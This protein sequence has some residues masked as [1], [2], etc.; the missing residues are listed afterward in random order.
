MEEEEDIKFIRRCLDLA[1][2]AEGSTTP[3]P[4]VGSV[5]VHNGR[6]IGEGYHLKSGGPH[7]EVIAINSVSDKSLLSHSTLYVNLEPCSH[8]GKTPPCADYIISEHIPRVVVGT[9]D[10][11]AK[12]SGQGVS[13]LKDAGCEVITGVCEDECRRLNRRFFTF[14]EK[15]RPYI[16]LKWAKSA[17]G[18]ID[19]NRAEGSISEPTW[20]SG[21]PERVLVHRWRASEEAIL[22]GAATIR[23][24]NP[25]LNIREWKGRDPV[26]IIISRSGSIDHDSAINKTDGTLIVFT[27]NIDAVL[28]K[29]E[30]VKLDDNVSVSSQVAAYLYNRG[31]QSLLIEGGAQILNHF[32]SEGFWDEARIFTGDILFKGGVKSPDI[33]GKV[34]SNVRFSGSLLKVYV[35][36]YI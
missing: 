11:S 1:I 14:H 2:K 18:Y 29:G 21:K 10:T 5:V 8:Y 30:K 31:V 13:R 3:N 20:I 6:I 4:M 9:V 15:K 19:I 22:A 33:N 26:K 27:E 23:A 36:E 24:D 34:I 12:V 25:R 16:T 32:I 28:A 17:D 35:N 7:A